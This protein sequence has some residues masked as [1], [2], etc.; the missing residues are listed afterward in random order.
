MKVEEIEEILEM[1]KLLE[2]E[3]TSLYLG[4]Q[5]AGCIC[6]LNDRDKHVL[7]ADKMTTWNRETPLIGAL[8]NTGPISNLL[9]HVSLLNYDSI[10]T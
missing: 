4:L 1:K 9:T 7:G 5:A 10:C 6:P 2:Y 3:G 8:Y